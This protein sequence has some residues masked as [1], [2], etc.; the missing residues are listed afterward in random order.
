MKNKGFSLMELMVVLTIL[1]SVGFFSDVLFVK[2]VEN[3][4][5]K[6]SS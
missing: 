4:R 2:S 5:V 6:S 3:D 1:V